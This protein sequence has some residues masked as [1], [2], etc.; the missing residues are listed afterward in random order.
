MEMLI[1]ECVKSL[2]WYLREGARVLFSASAMYVPSLKAHCAAICVMRSFL[3]IRS[4]KSQRRRRFA[5]TMP[6]VPQ[7]RE[8]I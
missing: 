3:F 2:G 4:L 5:K 6:S 1:G 7:R 8:N